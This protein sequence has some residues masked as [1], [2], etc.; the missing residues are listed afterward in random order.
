MH[1]DT[2]GVLKIPTNKGRPHPGWVCGTALG[3][4]EHYNKF[5]LK[6]LKILWQCTLN[7]VVVTELCFACRVGRTDG[8]SIKPSLGLGFLVLPRGGLA[9]EHF[10]NVIK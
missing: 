5:K 2:S 9:P 1:A 7:A 3:K 6:I 10:L 8:N 4:K